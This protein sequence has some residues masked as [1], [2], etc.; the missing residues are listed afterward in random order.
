MSIS[1]NMLKITVLRVKKNGGEVRLVP[2]IL[3]CELGSKSRLFETNQNLPYERSISHVELK[4]AFLRVKK[5]GV[6]V[7]L[8]P[9]IMTGC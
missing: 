3:V 6:E 8:V 1:H 2:F 4:L 9:F 7:R 5:N